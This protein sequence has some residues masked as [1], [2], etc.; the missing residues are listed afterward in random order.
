MICSDIQY[1]RGGW[2]RG[3]GA[4]SILYQAMVSSSETYLADIE[5]QLESGILDE[6]SS[7]RLYSMKY[8]YVYQRNING[9]VTY[10]CCW[11]FLIVI[12]VYKEP[13][14]SQHHQSDYFIKEQGNSQD[15]DGAGLKFE[16]VS[17][18]IIA[19]VHTHIHTH[20]RT[21]IHRKRYYSSVHYIAHRS[22]CVIIIQ[23]HRDV[24]IQPVVLRVPGC[25]LLIAVS[26]LPLLVL[27]ADKNSPSLSLFI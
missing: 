25:C 3:G 17:G 27:L 23:S 8:H 9:R 7:A 12:C 24:I 22:V 19:A 2:R 16:W 21:H 11:P 4:S 26:R 15:F 6:P 18:D 20:G 5:K 13:W 14:V 1:E 10:C